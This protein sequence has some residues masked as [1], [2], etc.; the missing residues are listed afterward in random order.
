M[1]TKREDLVIRRRNKLRRHRAMTIDALRLQIRTVAAADL[2]ALIPVEPQP[3]QTVEDP[4]DHL[5]RRPLDVGVLDA[6]HKDAAE[7]TREQPVEQ[8]RARAANVEVAGGRWSETNSG[9]WHLGSWGRLSREALRRDSFRGLPSRRSLDADNR[10]KAGRLLVVRDIPRQSS[11]F[12]PSRGDTVETAR[13]S[14]TQPVK[15]PC[16]ANADAIRVLTTAV[17][18]RNASPR[19]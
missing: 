19:R 14:P 11:A 15:R 8:R 16:E 18:G 10:A 9:S 4:G 6:Q 17:R 5:V 2:R 3:A 1:V 12:Y 13:H 7:P